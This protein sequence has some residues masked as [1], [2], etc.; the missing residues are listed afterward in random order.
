MTLITKNIA[1]T[2]KTKSFIS[3]EGQQKPKQ[4]QE[5]QSW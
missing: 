4:Y 3:Q 2:A 5:I 1:L